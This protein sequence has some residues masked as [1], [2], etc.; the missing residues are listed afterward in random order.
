[1][2]LN[3]AGT[4]FGTAYVDDGISLSPGPSRSLTLQAAEGTL[5]I[6]SNGEHKIE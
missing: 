5:E 6:E 3:A 4:A 2:S 1:V